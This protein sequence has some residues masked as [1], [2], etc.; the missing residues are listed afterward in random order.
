[1]KK[2]SSGFTL[3]E[4]LVVIAIIAILAAIL[5]P[6]FSKARANARRTVCQSN[7]KQIGLSFVQYMQDYDSRFP[8]D[9]QGMTTLGW[10]YEIQPYTKSEQI[11]QCPDED[12]DP[13]G[14]TTLEARAAALT[15]SD[16]FYNINIGYTSTTHPS[17]WKE[18]VA[19]YPTSTVLLGDGNGSGK[20]SDSTNNA[21]HI[22]IGSPSATRHLEGANY[23]FVDGHVKWV[24]PE[25]VLSGVPGTCGG[26]TTAPSPDDRPNGSNNTFCLF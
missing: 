17:P 15:F 9:A 14:G 1:M 25:N 24:K 10:A 8:L 16:Y 12:S 26:G 6:V 4:L 19:A 3:I 23:V 21:D 22:N 2:R 20:G 11:L 7:L 5:F 18:G 13:I